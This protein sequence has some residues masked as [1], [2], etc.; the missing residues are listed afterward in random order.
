MVKR[1]KIY[2]KALSGSKNI[3]FDEFVMLLEGFGFVFRR[4]TGS[5]RIFKHPDVPQT[6]SAQPDKNG[7][8]KPYQIRKLLKM[9]EEHSLSLKEDDA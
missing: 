9:V 7:Q 3:R 4:I 1:S 6:F 2:K 5:H 8:T